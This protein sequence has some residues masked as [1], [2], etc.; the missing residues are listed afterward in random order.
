M[1]TATCCSICYR[2]VVPPEPPVLEGY[3]NGSTARVSHRTPSFNLTCTAQRAKPAAILRWFRNG[4]ELTTDL[5]G[6][7]IAYSVRGSATG[8]KLEDSSSVLS[9]QP[10][11]DDNEA[12]YTCLAVAGDDSIRQLSVSVQLHVLRESLQHKQK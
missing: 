8:G 3:T 11:N 10:K 12:I 4:V 9:F 5:A 1:M 7:S 6:T 2:A